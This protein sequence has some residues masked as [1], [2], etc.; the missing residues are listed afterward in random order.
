[1]VAFEGLLLAAQLIGEVVEDDPPYRLQVV[2][3][4]PGRCW[5]ELELV[6]D[7][8]AT[9]V[10]LAVGRLP[11]YPTVDL[12]EVRDRWIDALN[13]LDWSDPVAPQPPS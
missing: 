4:D 3:S 12:D 8:G 5:S 7:A 9:T 1:M 13:R 11:G 10:A 6:P 2:L